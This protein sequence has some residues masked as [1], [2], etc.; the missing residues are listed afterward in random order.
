MNLYVPETLRGSS[1]VGKRRCCKEMRC[2]EEGNNYYIA[3]SPGV[4]HEE[5]ID[6]V[7]CSVD[8]EEQ[9]SRA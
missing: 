9:L 6:S 4:I 1:R 2:G 5:S 3:T 8:T 7:I